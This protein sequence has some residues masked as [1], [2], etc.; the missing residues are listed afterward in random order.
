MS[1]III[2]L[3]RESLEIAL[4]LG[5]IF[6]ATKNVVGSKKQILL[7]IALG[8][9]GSIIIAFFTKNISS[10]FE[11]FG[12]EIFNIIILSISI[13][14][15]GWTVIW[16]KGKAKN[17]RKDIQRSSEQLIQGRILKS[18]LPLMVATF[19]FREGT[20]II[21]FVYSVL[22]IEK[23]SLIQLIFGISLGCIAGLIVGTSLYFGLIQ[24][25]GKRLFQVTS[26]LLILIAASLAAE[27]ANLLNSLDILSEFSYSIW[28]TS[29][30]ITD[31][32]ITGKILNT[33]IGYQA[34]P[35]FL[36]ILFYILTLASILGID[37]IYNRRS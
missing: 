1:K 11:G 30:L 20:E 23:I 9:V 12:Q 29:W 37:K 27:V 33:L 22:T 5:T 32:S 4:L 14:M 16:M 35:T 15:L 7:G 25:S 21:L 8:V 13:I 36:Q 6:A 24:Y 10:A 3:F 28:D 34:R 2:I 19:F 26:W 31:S 18:A 17:L